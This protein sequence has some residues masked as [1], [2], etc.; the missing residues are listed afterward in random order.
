MPMLRPVL[1]WLPRVVNVLHINQ[2]KFMCVLV[3]CLCPY[4]K[5]IHVMDRLKLTGKTDD[6]VH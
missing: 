6:S 5:Y 2:G 3:A 1:P 4:V